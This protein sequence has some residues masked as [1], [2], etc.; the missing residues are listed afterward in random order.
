MK[1]VTVYTKMICPF[2]TRA[3]ELLESKGARIEQIDAGFDREKKAEMM[4][5]SGGRA[6]FPQ[7]FIGD[8]HVG[9]FDE[10]AALERQGKLDAMLQ[11]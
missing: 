1:P 4:Q 9:G 5:K 10:L 7:I 6:T 2:C 3:M 11:G 8:I